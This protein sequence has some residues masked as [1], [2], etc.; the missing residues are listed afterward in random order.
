MPQLPDV[1]VRCLLVQYGFAWI[2][3]YIL[4]EKS[5]IYM[6]Q[7]VLNSSFLL[8]SCK[9]LLLKRFFICLRRNKFPSNGLRR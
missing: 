5:G 3:A 8:K 2:F 6:T 1:C 4:G 7:S 9:Y